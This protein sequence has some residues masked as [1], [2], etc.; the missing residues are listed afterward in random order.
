LSH[1]LIEC[2]RKDRWRLTTADYCIAEV[3]KTTGKYPDGRGRWRR[4]IHP[5]L[6]VDGSIYV[7][8]R[9]IVFEA[10]K[11]RPVLLSAI[12]ANADYLVTSD[13]ADFDHVR[14]IVVYGVKVRTPKTFLVEMG[15]VEEPSVIPRGPQSSGKN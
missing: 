12:G 14:G 13:R 11:D 3:E 15:L 8:N 10:T 9:P 5:H 1:A 2:G 7:I 6:D 4:V